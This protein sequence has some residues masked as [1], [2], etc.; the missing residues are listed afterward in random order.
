MK[1]Y[2]EFGD[3]LDPSYEAPVYPGDVMDTA[4]GDPVPGDGFTRLPTA[5]GGAVYSFDGGATATVNAAGRVVGGNVPGALATPAPSL[6]LSLLGSVVSAA[7]VLM[8][9]VPRV[10]NGQTVAVPVPVVARPSWQVP[11][12]AV[13]AVLLLMLIPGKGRS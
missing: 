12:L 2:L 6:D 11:A 3:P 7:G 8:R 4:V 10:S 1:G 5:D 13:G 9:Y